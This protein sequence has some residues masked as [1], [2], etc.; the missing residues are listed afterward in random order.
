M[1][2]GSRRTRWRP[3]TPGPFTAAAFCT[4]L[5]SSRRLLDEH[6]DARPRLT[7]GS[8]SST[9]VQVAP[10]DDDRAQPEATGL[11]GFLA[12]CLKKEPSAE[13]CRRLVAEEVFEQRRSSARGTRCAA[14]CR[15]R[16][17]SRSRTSCGP[18]APS[19]RRSRTPRC[20]RSSW[21]N[22]GESAFFQPNWHYFSDQERSA[23]VE[24]SPWWCWGAKRFEDDA[25]TFS[26]PLHLAKNLQQGIPAKMRGP[27][28][29]PA[30]ADAKPRSPL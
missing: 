13:L 26:K 22:K 19:C 10:P 8:P 11:Y 24:E 21:G 1:S 25:T 2:P 4:S 23:V 20:A 3:A 17:G 5:S 27:A 7:H 9:R 18:T 29:A 30:A 12:E 16:C 6:A 15:R 28:A 14:R